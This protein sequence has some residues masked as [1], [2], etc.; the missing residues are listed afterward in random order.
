MQP[1][2]VTETTIS[3]GGQRFAVR[4]TVCV[5]PLI[6]AYS[7]GRNPPFAFPP[8]SSCPQMVNVTIALDPIST[9]SGSDSSTEEFSPVAYE[10]L[11]SSLGGHSLAIAG[12]TAKHDSLMHRLELFDGVVASL[13]R[14]LAALDMVNFDGRLLTLTQAINNNRLHQENVN[15]ENRK[16]MVALEE[17]NT[18]PGPILSSINSRAA[19]RLQSME[20]F[21]DKYGPLVDKLVV[22]RPAVTCAYPGLAPLVEQL[23]L[24]QAFAAKDKVEK[25]N[26]EL[27]IVAK[28]T[29]NAVVAGG[30]LA[31]TIEVLAARVAEC[32]VVCRRVAGLLAL[33]GGN[34][35]V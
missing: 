17:R 5:T 20:G 2:N 10:E 11:A 24:T 9:S 34:P 15:T 19:E 6:Q 33:I 16:R 3:I 14:H 27:G 8:T 18:T 25:M 28:A 29:G 1:S 4:P 23:K 7:E 22:E 12:L 35:Q 21:M 26:D 31:D 30:S 13:N 32:E